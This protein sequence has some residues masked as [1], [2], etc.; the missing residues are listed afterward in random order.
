[1]PD[2]GD[3]VGQTV[4]QTLMRWLRQLLQAAWQQHQRHR[5]YKTPM[6]KTTDEAV[7]RAAAEEAAARV[8]EQ[9]GAAQS[10][11][12]TYDASGL[13]WNSVQPNDPLLDRLRA[14]I[15]DEQFKM[16][17]FDDMN[18]E[19]LRSNVVEP[20]ERGEKF[21]GIFETDEHCQE[22]M[23]L[24]HS[25]DIYTVR[26]WGLTNAFMCKTSDVGKVDKVLE[27]AGKGE[28]QDYVKQRANY[29]NLENEA[30][31]AMQQAE[32]AQNRAEPLVGLGG[33]ALLREVEFPNWEND[34]EDRVFQARTATEAGLEDANID[35]GELLKNELS[36]RGVE[37]VE[38]GGQRFYQLSGQGDGMRLDADTL[39]VAYA[40]RVSSDP[41]QGIKSH[42]GMDVNPYSRVVESTG[43]DWRQDILQQAEQARLSAKTPEEYVSS[44]EQSGITVDH[45]VDGDYLYKVQG[46]ENHNISGSRLCEYSGKEWF[47][48]T[49]IESGAVLGVGTLDGVESLGAAGESARAAAASMPTPEMPEVAR[50][51]QVL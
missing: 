44:L 37:V 1:M 17:H 49:A 33:A 31:K 32:Q 47:S 16:L 11:G 10:A 25:Q 50:G 34:L 5:S 7:A 40:N 24:L 8:A 38:D 19:T 3:E 51:G 26:P 42:D 13:T 45:T 23:A 2:M 14:Q 28:L 18:V 9:T 39:D 27:Q 6:N 48:S 35:R 46:Q 43:Y 29:I 12:R 41:D 22:A 20:I 15:G 30:D 21:L 36:Q 4:E